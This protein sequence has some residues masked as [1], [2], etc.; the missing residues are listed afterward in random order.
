M[1]ASTLGKESGE[2]SRLHHRREFIGEQQNQSCSCAAYQNGLCTLISSKQPDLNSPARH[3]YNQGFPLSPINQTLYNRNVF[4][5]AIIYR[6]V[7][8]N[9][10]TDEAL[11]GEQHPKYRRAISQHVQGK[12]NIKKYSQWK[13]WLLARSTRVT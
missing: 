9:L 10:H 5:S 3:T 1:Q 2:V 11:T 8:F 13:T 6:R 12:N 4:T 7:V